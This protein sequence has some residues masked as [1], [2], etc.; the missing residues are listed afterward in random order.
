VANKRERERLGAEKKE[1]TL[2]LNILFIIDYSIDVVG[3]MNLSTIDP[4]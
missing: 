3:Q 4:F 1:N 2:K